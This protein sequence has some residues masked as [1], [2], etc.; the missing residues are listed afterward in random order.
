MNN[1]AT[2]RNILFLCTGD[3]CR[4]PM[5]AGLLRKLLEDA[6]VGAAYDV[7]SAGVMTVSSLVATPES[8]Q[9]GES[10]GVTLDRHRST[11]MT[12]ELL[13]KADLILGMTPLHV[14]LA[15][16]ME[17]SIRSKVH[18]LKEFTRSDL[19]KVQID[20]PMGNT[21]E[22]YKKVFKEIKSCCQRVMK[23]PFITG[24][25]EPPS[26]R[27]AKA[28]KSTRKRAPKAKPASTAKAPKAAEKKP[29]KPAEKKPAKPAKAA[30]S[31]SKK[32]SA[33]PAPKA[34]AK[35]GGSAK[36]KK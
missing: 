19:K 25:P 8:K 36:A 14:Q 26:D 28:G 31:A 35:S 23:S 12:T 34:P 24:E 3:T 7:K 4:G 5:A 33:K 32:P 16:R 9:M 22:V 1:A 17:P 10:V 13:R 29:A 20:D 27:A 6:G 11:P 15:L 18:L 30:P 2:K 21:L